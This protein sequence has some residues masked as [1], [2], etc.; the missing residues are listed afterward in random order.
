MS[1][2]NPPRST[3][4]YNASGNSSAHPIDRNG[5]HYHSVPPHQLN[6]NAHQFQPPNNHNMSEVSQSEVSQSSPYHLER[7]INNLEREHGALR[8]DVKDLK[9]LCNSLHS[10]L[11]TLKKGGW[12][13]KIGPFKDQNAAQFRKELD[14]LSAE[15]KR[16]SRGAN[17]HEKV[18]RAPSVSSNTSTSLPPHLRGK[19]ATDKSVSLPPHLRKTVTNE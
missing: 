1:D 11:D 17:E 18:N 19:A 8:T 7:K 12:D 13:V 3:H 4:R 10:S 15:A 5:S 9:T 2:C 6:P 16:D 14:A